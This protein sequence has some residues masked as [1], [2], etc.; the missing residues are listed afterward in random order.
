MVAQTTLNEAFC[1]RDSTSFHVSAAPDHRPHLTG[2]LN[3]K[4]QLYVVSVTAL[5]VYDYF[6]TFNDEVTHFHGNWDAKKSLTSSY[7]F[8]TRGK[9]RALPVSKPWCLCEALS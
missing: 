8:D 9:R 4:I 1:C 5:L 2:S 6:L 3:V 7:R